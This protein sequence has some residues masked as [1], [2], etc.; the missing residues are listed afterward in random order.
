ME[1]SGSRLPSS[2]AAYDVSAALGGV[3]ERVLWVYSKWPWVYSK[4]PW[5]YSKWTSQETALQEVNTTT[6]W[7]FPAHAGMNRTTV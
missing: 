4:W 5:V 6:G 2:T 3:Q 1:S 7:V